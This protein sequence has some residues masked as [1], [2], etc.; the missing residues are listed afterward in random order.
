MNVQ[1][2]VL[3][4]FQKRVEKAV[5][6]TKRLQDQMEI[7]LGNAPET[8]PHTPGSE[9]S[10]E[11]ARKIEPRMA[12]KRGRLLVAMVANWP[13][14]ATHEEMI[15]KLGWPPST[16]RTR[17]SELV[18]GGFVTDTGEVKDNQY[19][20]AMAIWKPTNRGQLWVRDRLAQR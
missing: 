10:K 13:D 19:G 15:Q 7:H 6:L 5:D 17:C 14:G 18:E 4:L 9:T 2:E 3:D 12:N 8:A 1:Q 20:N 16:L 11:A